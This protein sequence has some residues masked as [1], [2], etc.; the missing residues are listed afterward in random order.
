MFQRCGLWKKDFFT[1]TKKSPRIVEPSQQ[2][3]K[4]TKKVSGFFSHLVQLQLGFFVFQV[5]ELAILSLVAIAIEKAD[6]KA[7]TDL[8]VVFFV[9]ITTSH[10]QTSV[11]AEV[12]IKRGP[13]HYHP[14]HFTLQIQN[15]IPIHFCIPCA[16]ACF[17]WQNFFQ[18]KARP[19]WNSSKNRPQDAQDFPWSISQA[20]LA[21]CN[22]RRHVPTIHRRT[23]RSKK[24]GKTVDDLFFGMLGGF[25]GISE[26]KFSRVSNKQTATKNWKA[27]NISLNFLTILFDPIKS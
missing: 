24:S 26:Q 20:P 2:L 22:S 15:K 6:A 13:L 27:K 12:Q 4:R 17:G 16:P 23:D 5:A 25:V 10:I 19:T 7:S 8:P 18:P 11:D 9:G 3:K 21:T 1:T 14:K